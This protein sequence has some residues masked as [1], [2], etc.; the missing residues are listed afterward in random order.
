MAVQAATRGNM[1]CLARTS[2]LTWNSAPGCGQRAPPVPLAMAARWTKFASTCSFQNKWSH[3]ASICSTQS[4]NVTLG[5]GSPARPFCGTSGAGEVIVK[6]LHELSD[7]AG[8]IRKGLCHRVVV[9]AGAGLST[10]SGIPDFRSPTTGLYDNLQKYNLPYPEAVFDI[11]Y[12]LQDPRPFLS[13]ARE[14]YPGERRPNLGH[15]FLRLLH[16]RGLLLRLYTQNIDGLERVAGLPEDK[17][18]E[19]HGSFSTA[20]CT[21]C[22][23]E[24]CGGDVR[25]VIMAGEIPR[26][27]SC[28]GIV[29][30]DIVFFGEDLPERFHLYQVDFPLADLL[31]V[32]GTS[33]EVEPFGSLV[34]AVRPGIPRVLFNRHAVGPF[35][36]PIL[37]PSDLVELGELVPRVEAFVAQLGWQVELSELM[38]DETA[39]LDK[40]SKA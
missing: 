12:F 13:L 37:A 15:Y 14:L 34:H 27:K 38:K 6:H 8:L 16:E 24:H 20:F 2:K 1:R 31:L 10:P 11:N 18:V 4:R 39:K 33:L 25:S 17:L 22:K 9:M 5:T 35:A 19:A 28:Q 32:M 7:V 36:N 40:L 30:P 26:C 29:K 21:R 3:R 23:R